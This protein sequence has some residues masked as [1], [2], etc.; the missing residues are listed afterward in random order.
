MID[1]IRNQ[2]AGTDEEERQIWKAMLDD[3]CARNKTTIMLGGRRLTVTFD[4]SEMKKEDIVN[5]WMEEG[6]CPNAD[7]GWKVINM[8][9]ERYSESAK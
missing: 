1:K 7:V 3:I 2:F 5:R 8:Y 6:A 4:I 9:S